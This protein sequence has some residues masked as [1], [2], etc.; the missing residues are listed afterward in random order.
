M[1]V[2]IAIQHWADAIVIAIVVVLNTVI[3]FIQEYRAENAIQALMNRAR[4]NS[5]AGRPGARKQASCHGCS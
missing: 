1:V 3:G 2:T 4:R 5:T